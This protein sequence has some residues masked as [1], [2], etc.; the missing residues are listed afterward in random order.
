MPHLRLPRR[1]ATTLSLA[2]LGLLLTGLAAWH[3]RREPS[4]HSPAVQT[5]AVLDTADFAGGCFWGVEGVFEHVK[6]VVSATAGYAGGSVE[7]PHATKR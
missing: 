2:T 5:T 4:P 1:L 3:P 6:G 7:S